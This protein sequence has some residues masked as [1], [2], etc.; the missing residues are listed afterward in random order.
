MTKKLFFANNDRWINKAFSL[1]KQKYEDNGVVG[2]HRQL[3]ISRRWKIMGMSDE[4]SIAIFLHEVDLQITIAEFCLLEVFF[5]CKYWAGAYRFP[6][7]VC[8]F[9]FVLFPFLLS[10]IIFLCFFLY[11][12]FA[13]V[14]SSDEFCARIAKSLCF[15]F[16]FVQFILPIR[17]LKLE[18]TA[19][20]LYKVWTR[21]QQCNDY[22][23]EK[24]EIR[25]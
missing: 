25:L 9:T 2:A 23:E 14:L 12:Y 11:I 19:S 4:K 5:F 10:S 6:S 18:K 21:N 8:F 3:L 7:F 16:C 17:V 22:S 20:I 15:L 24:N 13:F 1:R